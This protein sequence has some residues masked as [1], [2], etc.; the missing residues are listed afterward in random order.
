MNLFGKI[1]TLLIFFLSVTFLIVAIMVGV[2]HRDWNTTASDNNR[3]AQVLQT[4]LAAA[5]KASADAAQQLVAE[6]KARQYQLSQLFTEL[7][8]AQNDLVS[9]K[10]DNRAA[11]EKNASIMADVN[12][13]NTQLVAQEKEINEIK[14]QNSSLRNKISTKFEQ[15]GTM[16]KELHELQ[17]RLDELKELNGE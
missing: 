3:D 7:Q 11:T 1:F 12:V 16:T 6:E 9:A 15:A 8:F 13:A 2:S 5:K 4:R 10:D 14:G 17:R